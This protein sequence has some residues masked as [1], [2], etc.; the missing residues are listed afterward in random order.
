MECGACM[1]NCP[2][3]CRYNK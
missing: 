2:F 3:K 1:K